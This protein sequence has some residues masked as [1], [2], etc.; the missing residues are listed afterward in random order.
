MLAGRYGPRR[1]R[2]PRP[3]L[4]APP[5]A[6]PTQAYVQAT[7]GGTTHYNGHWLHFEIPI[8]TTYNPGANPNNWFWSLRYTIST[9]STATDT[10]TIAVGL[11]GNPA[12]LL[13]S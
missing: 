2:D 9:G 10:V 3:V 11:K 6:D 13:I 8:P 7:T 1:R 5:L 12:H 4:P